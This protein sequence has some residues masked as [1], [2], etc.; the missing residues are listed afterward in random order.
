MFNI[1]KIFNWYGKGVFKMALG[2]IFSCAFSI[3]VILGTIGIMDGFEKSVKGALR[4]CSG[5]L[6]VFK[7]SVWFSHA[8]DDSFLTSKIKSVYAPV[9]Q[10]EAFLIHHEKSSAVLVMGVDEKSFA[11]VVGNKFQFERE[12]ESGIVVGSELLKQQKIAIGDEVVLAFANSGGEQGDALLP[13]L[14]RLRVVGEIHHGIYKKDSRFIYIKRSTLQAVTRTSEDVY[15]L[16][17][18]RAGSNHLD[19]SVDV[20]ELRDQLQLDLGDG[21]LVR[22]FWQEY[23]LLFQ[24][25]KV[26]KFIIALVLQVIVVISIFNI[27]AF[28]IFFNERHAAEIFLLETLGVSK[29]KLAQL[30]LVA[31]LALWAISSALAI[32]LV[33]LLSYALSH[34]SFLKLPGEVYNL[35]RLSLELGVGDYL[36]VFIMVLAWI[37]LIVGIGVYRLK[38]RSVLLGLRKEFL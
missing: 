21:F 20:D 4:K 9:L 29:R 5:D 1:L 37:L 15:N 24:A 27:L 11:E 12:G 31:V 16:L 8:E 22:S 2:A 14:E 38:K 18:V 34:L 36:L 26:E 35:S 13:V 19:R 23:D 7:K 3:T 28:L 6:L 10:S 25:V 17:M 30:W 33:K 32:V